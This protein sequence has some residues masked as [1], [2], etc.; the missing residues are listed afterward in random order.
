[1][2]CSVVGLRL[3]GARARHVRL[4][5]ERGQLR[6]RPREGAVVN[7]K[8]ILCVFELRAADDRVKFVVRRTSIVDISTSIWSLDMSPLQ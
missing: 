5:V 7:S 3:V 8:S 1:M 2:F 4:L 6:C